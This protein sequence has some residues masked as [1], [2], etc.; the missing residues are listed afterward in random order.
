MSIAVI[1]LSDPCMLSNDLED[2]S[3]YSLGA[4]LIKE[5]ALYN[6]DDFDSSYK[7]FI[8]TKNVD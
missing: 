4:H 5:H 3:Y 1:L 8:H 2:D 6:R 7:I